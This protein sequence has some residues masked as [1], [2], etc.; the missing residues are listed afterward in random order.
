MRKKENAPIPRIWISHFTVLVRLMQRS[1]TSVLMVSAAFP[2]CLCIRTNPQLHIEY[3]TRV[4]VR[5]SP[6]KRGA[7]MQGV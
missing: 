3:V 7:E 5:S 6:C 1:D 4:D 2:A